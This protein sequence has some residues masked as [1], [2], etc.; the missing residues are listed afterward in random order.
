VDLDLWKTLVT[1]HCS[2]PVKTAQDILGHRSSDPAS[3]LDDEFLR[4]ALTSDITEPKGFLDHMGRKFHCVV[5]PEHLERFTQVIS[6]ESTCTAVFW[7]VDKA[8]RELER[9]GFEM[10]VISNLWPFPARHIFQRMRIGDRSLGSFFQHL[11]YSYEVHHRK[12]EPQIFWE[13]C[14]RHGVKPSQILMVGDN[15]KADCLGAIAIGM[16]AAYLDRPGTMTQEEI[17]NLPEG[18]VYIRS[19]DELLEILPDRPALIL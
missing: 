19:L 14:R 10:G 8:L 13:A 18:I 12:P 7:D 4:E 6:G 16:R 9:R 17:D 15:L 1:S 2:E 11:I 5:E 3:D